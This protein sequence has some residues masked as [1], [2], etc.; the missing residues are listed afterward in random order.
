MNRIEAVEQYSHAVKLGQKYLHDAVNRSAY[1]YP[2]VLDEILD[3]RTLAGQ[4][5]LGVVNIPADL[6]IGTRHAGRTAALA[7][8][9]MPLL[10]EKTEFAG[11]WI[12]LCEAHLSDE[13]IR[14]PIRCVEYLG[15][16]YVEEGNK[17]VSVL[18]SY[19][20]PMIPG[21]VTRLIPEY[22]EEPEILLYYEFLH[23]YA[24]TGLYGLS[25][26]TPGSYTKLIA[27]LGL[28]KDHVWTERERKSFSAGFTHFCSAF[29]RL[30]TGDAHVSPA[31][32]LLV[33]LEVFPFSEIKELTEPELVKKLTSLWPDIRAIDRKP[34]LE[35]SSAAEEK[36]PSMLSHLLGFTRPDHLQVAFIYAFSPETSV[37]TRAHDHGR[38]YLEEKLGSRVTVQVYHA[39]VR[40]YFAIMEQAVE[41]GADILFAT[42]PTMLDACRRIA[43]LHKDVK[44]MLC[45][46]SRPYTGVR[47]YYSRIYEAKFISGAIA[48][49]MCGKHPIG[50]IARYP[51]L[52]VPAS[53]NAF[54]LGVR[55]TNPNA[56]IQLQW[57]CLDG[58]P[59]KQLLQTGAR[60]I[61][62]HP[63]AVASPGNVSLSWSTSLMLN[64]GRMM[65]LAS[66]VWNWG[67]TYEQMVRSV[68]AG[69]WDT[70]VPRGTSVSYW[71]GMSSGVINIELANTL[72]D[73][74][75]QLANILKD[76]LTRNTVHP[77][78][79][80]ITDQEGNIRVDPETNL[81]PEDLMQMNWLCENVEGRIPTM[82]ELLPMSRET[83]ELLALP[84]KETAPVEKRPAFSVSLAL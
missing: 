11:K 48:G 76:G 47:M 83:T 51:I 52:G 84:Q 22:S 38:I 69:A 70:T 79:G 53:I 82:D 16:F 27:S 34:A 10:E 3:E 75:R 5:S 35:V 25:F 20:A 59:Y 63:I 36:A 12:S 80:T 55:M 43:A 74:V 19:G 37:W 68:L 9:F 15:K 17:R 29:D 39:Y 50:Y 77:F 31:E 54:A 49:A 73:G 61:S 81:T 72:P 26:R 8:N 14:D 13:G 23:F 60:I 56:K 57:S 30:D 7:G 18:K 33:W 4:A 44:V 28:E 21:L 66:D 32:A 65:P 71:W 62:G 40:D 45:A 58:D 1:P 6:I 78:Q 41:D 67:R 2:L 24:L 42:T 64:D 46:L